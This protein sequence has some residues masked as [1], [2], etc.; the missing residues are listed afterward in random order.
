MSNKNELQVIVAESGLEPSKAQVMLDK[1]SEYFKLAAEWEQKAKAIVVTDESQVTEMK[2]ARVG[3]LML[4]EKRV[5]LEKTRKSLKEQALR[6]GKAIDGIANALKAVIVPIEED[7]YNKEHFVEHKRAAEEEARRI[8]ADRLLT[9]KEEADR[10]AR[11]KEIKEQAAENIRLKKEADEREA[12][13]EKE[14]K[15]AARKL[16]AEQD[17]RAAERKIA[18]EA[19]RKDRET[20]EAR[21]AEER[22]KAA[23][24]AERVRK[25]TERKAELEREELAKK[26]AE[27]MRLASMVTCPHCGKQFSTED[28]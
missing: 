18:E 13:A 11:E 9:E 22:R 6:E 5:E 27:E 15:A 19:A 7:L 2:M 25:E 12:A 23:V 28:V 4:K 8:E 16:A 17:K 21:V 1:F 24:D 10:V 14:R 26:H 3:R 20:A